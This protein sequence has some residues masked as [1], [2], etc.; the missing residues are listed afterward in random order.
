VLKVIASKNV[1]SWAQGFAYI[2]AVAQ[3]PYLIA[4]YGPI[5]GGIMAA[6]KVASAYAFDDHLSNSDFAVPV[7]TQKAEDLGLVESGDIIEVEGFMHGA[8][9]KQWNLFRDAIE[10]PVSVSIDSAIVFAGGERTA[11]ALPNVSD[12]IKAPGDSIFL[13]GRTNCYF[14]ANADFSFSGEIEKVVFVG[15]SNIDL[16]NLE[17][18]INYRRV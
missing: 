7:S 12:T 2:V 5:M 18:I 3:A 15:I 10:P 8:E 13:K 11:Y 16:F 14:L 4:Q 1:W 6:A 17:N 9:P